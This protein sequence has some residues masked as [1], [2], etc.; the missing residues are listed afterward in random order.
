MILNAEKGQASETNELEETEE[1]GR[2][3]QDSMD[4]EALASVVDQIVQNAT[5]QKAKTCNS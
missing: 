5:A 4:Y 1:Q 2:N 3:E